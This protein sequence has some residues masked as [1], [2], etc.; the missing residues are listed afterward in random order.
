MISMTVLNIFKYVIIILKSVPIILL[1]TF[2]IGSKKCTIIGLEKKHKI[3]K[4]RNEMVMFHKALPWNQL[5]CFLEFKI[6][7]KVF[8]IFMLSNKFF[9]FFSFEK[10]L[11]KGLLLSNYMFQT[12]TFRLLSYIRI[13]K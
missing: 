4:S 11:T 9:C 1:H 6:V 12:T 10:A 3:I 5:N 8:K 7:L 13:K 2:M